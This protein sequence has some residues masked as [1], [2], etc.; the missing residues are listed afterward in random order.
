MEETITTMPTWLNMTLAI[1]TAFGGIEF[2]KWLVSLGAHRRKDK[3]QAK[4]EEATAGQQD[5]DLRQKEYELMNQFVETAKQQFEDMKGRYDM[6]LAEKNDDRK[7]KAELRIKVAELE[8]KT[9]G[10]QRAFTESESRRRSAERLYCSV[11]S[12]TKRKPPIG[13]YDSAAI[14]ERPRR[15]NGQFEK[16]S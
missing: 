7:I 10:L 4:Q 9:D 1:A 12:C 5:A 2:V 3:A 8:R 11:E 16:M 15:E 6:L 13:T 14:H